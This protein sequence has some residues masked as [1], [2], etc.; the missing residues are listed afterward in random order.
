MLATAKELTTNQTVWSH[1]Q[2]LSLKI[3]AEAPHCNILT[4]Y[5]HKTLSRSLITTRIAVSNSMLPV[6]CKDHKFLRP[7]LSR[8]ISLRLSKQTKTPSLSSRTK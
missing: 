7:L 8:I 3:V 5:L 4:F 1:K 6:M 2:K